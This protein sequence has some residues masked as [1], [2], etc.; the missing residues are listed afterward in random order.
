MPLKKLHKCNKLGCNNLTRNRYCK[1]H[2]YIELEQKRI[3]NRRYNQ[4]RTDDKEQAFYKTTGWK[5]ARKVALARDNY[6]CQDCLKMGYVVPAQ[7]VHH[8]IPIKIM[9]QLRLIIDNMICLCESCHQQR[10]RKLN[11]KEIKKMLQNCNIYN[12][13]K[14]QIM[15]INSISAPRSNL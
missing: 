2:E 6:L 1:E 15:R 8:I 11:E 12:D 5:Q 9:W 13:I 7:T 10:H 14:K 3:I 4:H